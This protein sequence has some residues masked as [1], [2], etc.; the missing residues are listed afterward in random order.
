MISE[1][2]ISPLKLLQT[3]LNGLK[4]QQ[5][6]TTTTTAT[7]KNLTCTIT[8]ISFVPWFRRYEGL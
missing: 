3:V 7:T 6:T 2:D 1:H 5:Q 8:S 4:T